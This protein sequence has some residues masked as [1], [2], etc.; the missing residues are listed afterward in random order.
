MVSGVSRRVSQIEQVIDPSKPLTPAMKAKVKALVDETAF[1]LGRTPGY[2]HSGRR[3]PYPTV[4]SEVHRLAGV[5]SY[6]EM[7]QRH[8]DPIVAELE[9]WIGRMREWM[10]QS[11]ED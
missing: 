9:R 2:A 10:K 4:W 7:R 3:K 5:S 8:Y 6:D 11:G 1:L